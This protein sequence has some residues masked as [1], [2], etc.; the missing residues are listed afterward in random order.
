MQQGKIDYY[1]VLS[2]GDGCCLKCYES[3]PGCL[4]YDCKCKKCY[5]YNKL[6]DGSGECE[7][8]YELIRERKIKRA[9]DRL[10]KIKIDNLLYEKKKDY[11]KNQETD[12]IYTCQKC[13]FEINSTVDLEIIPDKTPVCKICSGE[14]YLSREEIELLKEEVNM[15]VD[16][17]DERFY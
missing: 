16:E 6:Y 17:D 14:I 15:E 3:Y 1:S 13:G 9:K 12:N 2:I 5:W 4:C 11:Y 10:L 7:K 8:K